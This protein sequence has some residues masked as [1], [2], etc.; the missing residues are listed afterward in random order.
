MRIRRLF[1]FLR[2]QFTAVCHFLADEVQRM[3]TDSAGVLTVII[4]HTHY[5]ID[6]R[7]LDSIRFFN[8][9]ASL[10]YLRLRPFEF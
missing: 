9:G 4:G 7:H 3:A 6:G 1:P 2:H 5:R 8:P 10:R